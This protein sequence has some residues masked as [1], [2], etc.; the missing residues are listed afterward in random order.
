[1]TQYKYQSVPPLKEGNRRPQGE[2]PC[3]VTTVSDVQD[4]RRGMSRPF[5]FNYVLLLSVVEIKK[6]VMAKNKK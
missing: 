1:M 4:A 3:D 2:E 5:H 6:N